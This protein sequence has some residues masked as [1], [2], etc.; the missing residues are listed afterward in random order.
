VARGA[1]GELYAAWWSVRA[2]SGAD[3]RAARSADGG[4]TWPRAYAVDTLD[5]GVRGCARPA[6]S[7]AADAVNGFVHVAYSLDAPEGAGVFYSHLM[8]PA[9][10]FEPPVPVVYGERPAA[11][12]V[13]SHGDTVAVAYEDPNSRPTGIALAL[14]L[15][16]GHRFEYRSVGASGANVAAQRPGLALRGRTVAVSWVE[17]GQAD[18]GDDDVAAEAGLGG[19]PPV[20]GIAVVRLGTL[21]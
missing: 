16:A 11:T 4:R 20:P 13:A 12:A 15:T 9:A 19:G 8:A 17:R 18:G 1:S 5:R 6:P 21:R 3:L 7:I 10:R 2:D 14:S